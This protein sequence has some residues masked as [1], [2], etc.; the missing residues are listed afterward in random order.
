MDCSADTSIKEGAEI[1][2]INGI[3]AGDITSQLLERQIRD[4][5]NRT[6]PIWILTNY[7]K[8]YLSFSFGHPATF[9][10]TYKLENSDPQT[11]NV[12]S[13]SKDSIRFCRQAKYANRASL[14]KEKQGILLEMN[15]QLSSAVLCIKSFDNDVLKSVYKQDFDSAVQK[16]FIQISNAHI[17]NLIL[18]I[19]NN[20]GGDFE[21][22]KI[23]LSYL[24][25]QSVKY[26]SDSK[27]YEIIMP[28]GN[29]YKGN[30]FILINGGSFSEYRYFKLIF[31]TYKKR[32]FYWRRSSRK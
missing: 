7:F 9:T 26:L 19:R 2:S 31:R 14:T 25:R 16:V 6:Y 23:L 29:S 22:V 15:K 10:I 1:L 11:V 32:H 4:G 27:E 13:L 5:K 20:Q 30:L 21:P 18:D 24:L 3:S 8:E 28:K 12:N 17:Q